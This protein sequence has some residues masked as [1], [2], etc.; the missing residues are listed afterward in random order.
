MPEAVDLRQRANFYRRLANTATASAHREDGVL[1]M[2]AAEIAR[3][4]DELEGRATEA[5]RTHVALPRAFG[6]VYTDARR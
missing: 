1:L 6:Q 4:A 3:E 5:R 2:L